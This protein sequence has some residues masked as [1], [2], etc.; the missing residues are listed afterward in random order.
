MRKT[1]TKLLAIAITTAAIITAATTSLSAATPAFAK[2]DNCRQTPEAFKCSGGEGKAL[3]GAA[4]GGFGRTTTTT[5]EGSFFA[6]GFGGNLKGDVPQMVG[7][8]GVQQICD[9]TGCTERG[10][11]GQHEKGPGGNSGN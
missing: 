6:G 8:G 10:G 2:S 4:P 3:T 11:I 9:L 7:G 5:S 1:S